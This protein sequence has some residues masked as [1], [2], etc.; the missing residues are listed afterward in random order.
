MST[1]PR[2]STLR[3]PC[4]PTLSYPQS[5]RLPSLSSLVSIISDGAEEVGIG[6]LAFQHH[7]EH[8]HAQPGRDSAW[9]WLQCCFTPKCG[10]GAGSDQGAGA[11]TFEPVEAGGFPGPKSP[12]MLE[13]DWESAA[14][15]RSTGSHPANS[16]GHG[17]PAGIASSHATPASR[18]T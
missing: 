14:V 9:A 8:A 2:L 13:H 5:S 11:G 7:L 17:A 6:G 12:G 1:A 15:P 16:V 10:L 4:K 18:S 3:G